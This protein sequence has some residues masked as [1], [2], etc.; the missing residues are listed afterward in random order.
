MVAIPWKRTRIENWE[1]GI[2]AHGCSYLAESLDSENRL[3]IEEV[4]VK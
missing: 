2:V 3:Q 4:T 1:L